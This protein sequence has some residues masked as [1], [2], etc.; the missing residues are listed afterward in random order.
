MKPS[1]PETVKMPDGTILTYQKVGLCFWC[2]LPIEALQPSGATPR[3]IDSAIPYGKCEKALKYV[4][5]EIGQL[6]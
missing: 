1:P 6:K 3:H 5:E 2:G 4:S